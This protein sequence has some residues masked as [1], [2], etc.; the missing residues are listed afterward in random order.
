MAV[1]AAF[2][3]VSYNK[4]SA[5]PNP[6]FKEMPGLNDYRTPRYVDYE[7]GCATQNLMARQIARPSDLD[8]VLEAAAVFARGDFG[9]LQAAEK[10]LAEL[11]LSAA[12]AAKEV[13]LCS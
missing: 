8:E 1:K 11:Q 10:R 6:D 7:L 12:V 3:D 2:I 4:L 13:A 9:E 5:A